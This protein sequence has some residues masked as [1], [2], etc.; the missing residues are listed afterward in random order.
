[1][2]PAGLK[3][4]IAALL[5][6]RGYLDRPETCPSTNTMAAWINAGLTWWPSR[7]AP[8]DVAAI[9][10]IAAEFGVPLVGRGAG[11]G[12]CG[13][14][15]RE[16]A[17]GGGVR[18]DESDSRI[19]LD[20]ERAWSNRAWSTWISRWRL[21]QGYFYAPTL[22]A[23]APAPWAETSPKTPGSAHP[24]LWRDHEPRAWP[25]VRFDGRRVVKPAVRNPNSRLRPDGPAHRIRRH[26]GLVTK[27]TVRL[28][29]K[30]GTRQDHPGRVR[31]QR[32]RWAH[33]GQIAA[34]RSPRWR[35]KCSMA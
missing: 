17:A 10:K 29:R 8:D 7:A 15:I 16:K 30:V 5:G 21:G 28:M 34:A 24:G 33:R 25:G 14:A 19:D 11:T 22:P 31:F 26:H 3:D 6:P 1:M 23:S 20:N 27:F 18:S 32:G 13:G 4:R 9:V 12:L 2:V 35:S